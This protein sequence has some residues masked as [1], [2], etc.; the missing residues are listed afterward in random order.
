M[1]LSL[2][3]AL[4][5]LAPA[6]AQA[7]CIDDAGSY[8]GVSSTLL[9]AIAQHESGMRADAINRNTNGTED[10]GLMQI[11][12]SWLP[13]LARE[14]ITRTS[15]LDACINAYVGAWILSSNFAH[16]GPTWDAVGAYNATS[17]DKQIRYATQI[18]KTLRG[19]AR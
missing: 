9:R 19:D 11:N 13:K 12:S 8:A 17:P 16:Y 6:I 14:G 7:D 4:V 2:V 18:Y 15:L 10:I 1:R 3:V 5:V